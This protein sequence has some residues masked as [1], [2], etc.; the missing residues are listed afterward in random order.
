MYIK[1]SRGPR[2]DPCGTPDSTCLDGDSLP[3]R[4]TNCSLSYRYEN[5]HLRMCLLIPDVSNFCNS[6]RWGTESNALRKS[7]NIAHT[8]LPVS[9]DWWVASRSAETVDLPER[10]PHCQ[11]GVAKRG[12]ANLTYFRILWTRYLYS[13]LWHI[14]YFLTSTTWSI[15]SGDFQ[16]P[17]F[18]TKSASLYLSFGLGY[19]HETKFGR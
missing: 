3:F 5:S 10:N 19:N 1:K 2:T 9:N 16:P 14:V 4:T 8:S 11:I 18:F 6:D 17:T 13:V 12:D 15:T 7:K